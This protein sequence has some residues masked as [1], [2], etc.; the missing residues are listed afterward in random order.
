MDIE[1]HVRAY[2]L[3]NTDIRTAIGTR[4][5]PIKLPQTATFPAMTMQRISG[6]RFPPLKGRASL[7]RPRFQFDIWVRESATAAVLNQLREYGRLLVNWLEGKNIDVLD[8][9]VSPAEYRRISFEFISD[10]ETFE[11]DVNGGYYL[12]SADFYIWHQTG[13]GVVNG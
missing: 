10:T 4:L 2:V 9:D 1:K 8:D 12:Y 13:L 5:Y 11:P 7:A 6:V 3:A